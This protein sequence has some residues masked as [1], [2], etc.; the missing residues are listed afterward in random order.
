MLSREI[1][2]R[3]GSF[4]APRG[5]VIQHC[6]TRSRSLPADR[7]TRP[8][9]MRSSAW[10]DPDIG[11]RVVGRYTSK[12][13]PCRQRTPRLRWSHRPSSLCSHQAGGGVAGPMSMRG[14]VV[15]IGGLSGWSRV[16]LPHLAHIWH[17]SRFETQKLPL[18]CRYLSARY[19]D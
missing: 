3:K 1:I 10:I 2:L 9:T 7:I 14:E 6:F 19:W 8:F 11:C 17:V 5:A 13:T 15:M 16:V 12:Y 4:P 18:T